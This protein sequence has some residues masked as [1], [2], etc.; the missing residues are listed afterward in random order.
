MRALTCLAASLLGAAMTLAHPA[1][2]S[3]EGDPNWKICVSTAT[4]PNE[5][6]TACSAVIDA[7]TETGKKLAAAHCFRGHA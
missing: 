6:V 5:K 3:A 7:R 4:A 2:A 1:A